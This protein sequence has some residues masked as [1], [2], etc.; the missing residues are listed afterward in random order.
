LA[1]D[2]VENLGFFVPVGFDLKTKQKERELA[3][4]DPDIGS[5][6]FHFSQ[7]FNAKFLPGK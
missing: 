4:K 1:S 6:P 7:S 5:L 2:A 3:R